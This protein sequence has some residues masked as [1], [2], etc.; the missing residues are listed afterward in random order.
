MFLFICAGGNSNVCCT[1]AT[2]PPREEEATLRQP[3]CEACKAAPPNPG[4]W[5]EACASLCSAPAADL[6]KS[7]LLAKAKESFRRPTRACPKFAF[8]AECLLSLHPD[9]VI[10]G[11]SLTS[12]VRH[13]Q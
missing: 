2:P 10:I 12:T 8:T 9:Q 1:A 4:G 11:G 13:A 5:E 3:G 6:D 7:M